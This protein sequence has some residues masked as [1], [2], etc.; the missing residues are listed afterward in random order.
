MTS[1][2]TI[3]LFKRDS[4]LVLLVQHA[5]DE[6]PAS[7]SQNPAA[8]V[9]FDSF[10]ARLG[11]GPFFSTGAFL[12]LLELFPASASGSNQLVALLH[13]FVKEVLKIRT[14]P[15]GMILPFYAPQPQGDAS[16][17]RPHGGHLKNSNNTFNL[18][19]TER[20]GNHYHN[21]AKLLYFTNLDFPEIR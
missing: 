17:F 15:C 8:W 1:H 7:R 19:A 14:F 20:K 11:L 16:F 6:A 2:D 18:M 9:H 5:L 13:K 3:W 10:C 12:F 21:L 4:N